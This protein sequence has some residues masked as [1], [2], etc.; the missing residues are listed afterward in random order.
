VDSLS[1]RVANWLR[2]DDRRGSDEAEQQQIL[3]A[4][5]D[6]VGPAVDGADDSYIRLRIS[7]N[8]LGFTI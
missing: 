4:R 8:S 5:D 1:K 7:M 6:R 3:I 2:T